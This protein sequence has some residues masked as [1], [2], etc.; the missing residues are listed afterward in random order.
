MNLERLMRIDRRIIFLFTAAVII[1]PLLFP[2]QM[3]MGVQKPT[4]RFF[5]TVQAI[6]PER[7]CIL[8]ATDYLPQTEAENHPMTIA[9]L[10]HGLAAKIPVLMAAMYIEG[11][12]LTL[13]AM[14][15]VTDEFNA[16]AKTSADSVVYGRDIVFLGWQPPPIVPILGMGRSIAAVYPTDYFGNRIDSLRVMRNVRNY[17]DIGIV[18]SISAGTMPL[19]FVQYAQSKYGVKVGGGVTAVSAPDYYPY[20]ETGQFS[21]LLGGMKGAAEYEHLVEKTFHL[22]GRMR[23][24]EG[25]G[26]QST[27]HILIIVFVVIGNV[28][29]FAGRRKRS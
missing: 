27:A 18:C 17:D 7:Q 13:D 23:A 19:S 24:T 29:Y 5:D 4:Q 1:L 22:G 9:L 10:R 14:N 26:A 2:F 20:F 15:R 8:I 11:A 3:P 21:G 28:A 6:D 16:R 12:G 25:M